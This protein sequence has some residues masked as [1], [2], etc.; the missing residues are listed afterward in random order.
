MNPKR[1]PGPESSAPTTPGG[2]DARPCRSD[3]TDRE[4]SKILGGAIGSLVQMSDIDTVR[5]A[6][7]FWAE[8]DGLW[9]AIRLMQAQEV[10]VSLT[11]APDPSKVS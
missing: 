5:R 11:E 9:D 3:L 8:Q 10:M 4:A 1:S 2:L 6:V 7:R